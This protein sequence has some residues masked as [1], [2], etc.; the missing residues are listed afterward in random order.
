MNGLILFREKPLL[1]PS[2]GPQCG[3]FCQGVA[4]GADTLVSTK[5][6]VAMPG[7]WS[8]NGNDLDTAVAPLLPTV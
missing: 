6:T 2:D 4:Q 7:E 1:V 8:M 5:D 3:S